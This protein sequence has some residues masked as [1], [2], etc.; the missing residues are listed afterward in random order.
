MDH[1]V[2]IPLNTDIAKKLRSYEFGATTG[3]QRSVGWF[4]MV[5]ARTSQLLNGYNELAI[6]KLDLF[7]GAKEIK[8]AMKYKYKGKEYLF[9]P[10]DPNIVKNSKI[11]YKSFKG[12]EK[13]IGNCRKFSDL[14][15]EAQEYVKFIEKEM[16]KVSKVK[17]KY[18]S[19][20]PARD[21]TIVL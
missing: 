6:M 17:V 8:I 5:Q 7:S 20:G 18:V 10:S 3:R 9:S 16:N 14:P 4:D 13:N 2:E 1:P 12:W 21:Q 11:E 15:K 19:V